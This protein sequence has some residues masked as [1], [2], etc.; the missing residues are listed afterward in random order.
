MTNPSYLFKGFPPP[1]LMFAA[2]LAG[3]IALIVA[4]Q[5]AWSPLLFWP[6]ALYGL[7]ICAYL[8]N[9]TF[10]AWLLSKDTRTGQIPIWRMLVFAPYLFIHW[11]C[12]WLRHLLV[13]LNEDG[14]NLVAP[15]IYVGRFPLWFPCRRAGMLGCDGA[16][17][18]DHVGVVDMCAEFPALPWVIEQADGKYICL[19]CL[20]GDLPENKM[21]LL[22]AARTVAAWGSSTPVYIHCANGRGRSCCFAI[23]VILLRGSSKGD[24]EADIQDATQLI[25]QSRSQVKVSRANHALLAEVLQMHAN[26]L[27][28]S[29]S[30]HIGKP[31]SVTDGDASQCIENAPG[32]ELRELPRKGFHLESSTE[33][34]KADGN[35]SSKCFGLP[36]PFRFSTTV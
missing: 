14:Y 28:M 18:K 29:R 12:W 24:L 26:D 23:L 20:D 32:V 35:G 27:K 19:P 11:L 7:V 4:G 13:L 8:L 2:Y 31:W 25:R 5:G 16:L 22:R 21:E 6:A 10:G 9:G 3:A 15:G 33:K 34:K 36:P 17:P 30:S 1:L